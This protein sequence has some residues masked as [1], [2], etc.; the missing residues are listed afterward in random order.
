M[1]SKLRQLKNWKKIATYA[2]NLI[3]IR[4]SLNY[5]RQDRI[6]PRSSIKTSNRHL[7]QL[8]KSLISKKNTTS[9]QTWPLQH[10]TSPFRSIAPSVLNRSIMTA[11]C[12]TSLFI[13]AK[14]T[15]R[16]KS[17]PPAPSVYQRQQYWSSPNSRFRK[18]DA[19]RTKLPPCV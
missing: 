13:T 5:L 17:P 1:P 11:K 2:I 7:N 12:R 9:R 8:I 6:D 4:L 10:S 16:A 15:E 3:S 18:N 19:E 14:S